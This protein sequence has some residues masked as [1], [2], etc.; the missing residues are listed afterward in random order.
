MLKIMTPPGEDNAK[1]DPKRMTQV[2]F[3][4]KDHGYLIARNDAPA[5]LLY[6]G[7]VKVEFRGRDGSLIV[8]LNMNNMMSDPQYR[9]V[10]RS[11]LGWSFA[12]L[13]RSRMR[14]HRRWG[15]GTDWPYIKASTVESI[16]DRIVFKGTNMSQ[17]MV[18][19]PHATEQPAMP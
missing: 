16:A 9:S 4:Q 13:V 12:R 11:L 1:H 2:I 10:V 14:S 3:Q 15:S 8:H 18:T 19:M 5:P 17:P 6:M 7:Q